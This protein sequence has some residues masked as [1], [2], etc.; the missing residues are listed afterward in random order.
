MVGSLPEYFMQVAPAK[1]KGAAINYLLEKIRYKNFYGPNFKDQ[2]DKIILAAQTSPDIMN[3][4]R[5][6]LVKACALV[7][8]NIAVENAVRAALNKYFLEAQ[9]LQRKE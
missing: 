9:K 2:L 6:E 7:G 8:N 1:D 4:F 5:A 3:K